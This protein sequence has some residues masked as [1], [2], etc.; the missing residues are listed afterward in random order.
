M[1]SASLIAV[2][3][4]GLSRSAVI[5][6]QTP[7]QPQVMM[8]EEVKVATR[9][10]TRIPMKKRVRSAEEEAQWWENLL[11]H[12]EAVLNEDL[13]VELVE[14]NAQQEDT[15]DRSHD[16]T[17]YVQTGT[18]TKVSSYKEHLQ[19]FNECQYI[20]NIAMGT[21][22]DGKKTGVWSDL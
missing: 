16:E 20:G 18:G 6:V 7:L 11:A 3:L 17:S 21:A 19:D 10:R 22:K 2:S 14:E 8:E 13:N 15:A 5:N 9:V 1:A 4:L 12:H